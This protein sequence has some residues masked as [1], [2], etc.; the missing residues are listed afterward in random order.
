[1][2]LTELNASVMTEASVFESRLREKIKEYPAGSLRLPKK[3][4]RVR[5]KYCIP[6]E[7]FGREVMFD[8]VMIWLLGTNPTG[9]I[10]STGL[11]MPITAVDRDRETAPRGVLL[12][13]GP[14]ALDRLRDH[15][16]EVGDVINFTSTSPFRLWVANYAGQDFY[17][18]VM[19]VG[20]VI[21]T[22]DGRQRV[23]RGEQYTEECEETDGHGN[24][25]RVHLVKKGP[26]KCQTKTVSTSKKTTK[27]P[28]TKTASTSKKTKP[29][30]K[31]PRRSPVAKSVDVSA[32]NSSKR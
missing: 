30:A 3:L 12:G 16:A 24:S 10:G 28:V 26:G 18:M 11:I 29:P 8:W 7:A 9:E 21:A 5:L 25:R 19:K 6:H 20:W 4:D 1:M 23:L 15:G 13:A 27:Q 31:K 17:L 2:D 32:G 14:A 22:E